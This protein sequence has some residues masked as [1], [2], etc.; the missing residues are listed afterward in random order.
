MLVAGL[1][2]TPWVS[3]A[4]SP[5]AC[6]RNIAEKRLQVKPK[7][8]TPIR[9][10]ITGCL[11]NLYVIAG[12]VAQHVQGLQKHG[13]AAASTDTAIHG[14]GNEPLS[15]RPRQGRREMEAPLVGQL[16]V[17]PE[18]GD[19]LHHQQG[20]CQIVLRHRRL[21]QD[22]EQQGKRVCCHELLQGVAVSQP[23]RGPR[24]LE[25]APAGAAQGP[26]RPSEHKRDKG[27]VKAVA[28]CLHGGAGQLL[29]RGAVAGSRPRRGHGHGVHRLQDLVSCATPSS[30]ECS[31]TYCKQGLPVLV[32]H[33]HA[34]EV[35]G[36]VSTTQ[37]LEPRP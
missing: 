12:R 18:D 21:L 2:G 30:P 35:G 16:Q 33:R 26:S 13:R 36:D 24:D 23:L 32:R 22:A 14:S 1:R 28:E 31:F 4:G 34:P 17:N 5:A 27:T 29:E 6:S 15:Q 9:N 20:A 37:L 7:Q 8:A 10:K 11:D 19:D 3:R 25:A